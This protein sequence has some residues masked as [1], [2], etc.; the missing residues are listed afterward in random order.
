[1]FVVKIYLSSQEMRMGSTL[2]AGLRMPSR[3]LEKSKRPIL[4][5]G[6]NTIWAAEEFDILA[7]WTFH[8]RYVVPTLQQ[9]LTVMYR[10]KPDE[11]LLW[12]IT[13]ITSNWLPSYTYLVWSSLLPGWQ[14]GCGRTIQGRTLPLLQHQVPHQHPQRL[15]R[16]QH[17]RLLIQHHHPPW[18]LQ[19]P[20]WSNKPGAKCQKLNIEIN[21]LD[22]T[23]VTNCS[24]WYCCKIYY[25]WMYT[26]GYA[27]L[28]IVLVCKYLEG[29]LSWE[30]V[31]K[32][33]QM[34]VR[35]LESLPGALLL[36]PT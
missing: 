27:Q 15:H 35:V 10:T 8:I 12:L 19:H 5:G 32:S 9:G 24:D 13:Q 36:V 18:A 4:Q 11:P 16:P 23:W 31:K 7:S 3:R 2:E 21:I 1:M 6:H 22:G 28:N 26:C 30:S 33:E 34:K 29:H 20:G 14:T 25:L 17:L